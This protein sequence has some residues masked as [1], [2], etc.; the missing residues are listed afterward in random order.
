MHSLDG[1]MWYTTDRNSVTSSRTER[2]VVEM[3]ILA[4]LALD[5]VDP[6]NFF[7]EPEGSKRPQ[8]AEREPA[9]QVG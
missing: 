6:F 2:T 5:V 8:D 1:Y 7:R 9:P 3:S 4:L